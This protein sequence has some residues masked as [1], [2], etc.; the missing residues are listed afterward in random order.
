MNA[1]KRGFSLI[2]LLVVIA[3]IGVLAGIAMASYDAY[4][5]RAHRS[6]AQGFM[7]QVANKQS[8][9]ILDAR[10]Y[11]VGSTA[12]TS[13]SLT[14][15]PDVSPFYTVAV[16]N[17][18]GGTTVATPPSFRVRATPVVG[19]KQANDGELILTNTGAKTKGGA[20]GW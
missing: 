9:Y 10:N 18:T 1:S 19:S 6:A 17:G 11:A 15:P 5:V 4:V 12:L 7:M 2:E 20:S 13:L 14:V 3:S 8:Q 16:E